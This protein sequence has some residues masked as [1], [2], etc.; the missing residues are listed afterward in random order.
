M[1]DYGRVRRKR[2][3]WRSSVSARPGVCHGGARVQVVHVDLDNIVAE[4]KT[5]RWAKFIGNIRGTV[6]DQ[7]G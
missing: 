6:P 4:D 1:I 5:G 3:A 7:G 2:R